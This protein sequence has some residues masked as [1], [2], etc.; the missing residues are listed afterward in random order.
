MID[1]LF[2]DIIVLGGIYMEKGTSFSTMFIYIAMVIVATS[3]L[4]N[5]SHSFSLFYILRLIIDCGLISSYYL[6]TKERKIGFP[7]MWLCILIFLLLIYITQSPQ[8]CL[9]IL[10]S[11]EFLMNIAISFNIFQKL[12]NMK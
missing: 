5:L 2:C 9:T 10:F 12:K 7:L 6:L 4:V 8:Q 1:H 3:T 11:S